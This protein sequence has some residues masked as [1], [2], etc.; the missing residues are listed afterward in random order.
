MIRLNARLDG[1]GTEILRASRVPR[2]GDRLF[3]RDRAARAKPFP[4]SCLDVV[5]TDELGAVYLLQSIRD[6][7]AS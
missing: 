4:V 5:E 3:V 2:A 7:V 6:V 1:A